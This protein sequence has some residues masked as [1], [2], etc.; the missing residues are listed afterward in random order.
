MSQPEAEP[1]RPASYLV[2]DCGSTL[3]TVLLFEVVADRYR[4][5]GRASAPTTIAAPWSNLLHGLHEA[6]ERLTEITGRQFLSGNRLIRPEKENKSGVD[7]FL[8]VVSAA[9]PLRTIVVGLSDEVSLTSARHVLHTVY[10]DEVD[11]FSLG[12]TRGEDEQARAIVRQEPDLIFLVGGTDGGA[13]LRLQ[14]FART[15]SLAVNMHAYARQIPVLYAGNKNQR[16]QIRQI[17][18][19]D[20]TLYVADNVRPTLQA[21]KLDDASRVMGELYER[22]RLRELPGLN[23]V[24]AWMDQPPLPTAR[25]FATITRYFAAL[26]KGQVLGLELGT[27]SATL[28]LANADEANLVIRSDLGMGHAMA[29]LLRRTHPAAIARWLPTETSHETIRDFIHNKSL[30]PQTLPMTEQE[31]QLEHAIARELLRCASADTA[32]DWQTGERPPLPFRL[33]L[34]RG[35]VFAHAPRP[36]QVIAMILD[37]LQPVGIFAVLLDKVGVLPALGALSGPQPL[38]VVQ[39]L[40]SKVL[41]DL[42]WVVVPSGS[43]QPGQPAL[44]IRIEAE[45]QTQYEGV[46]DYGTLEVFPLAPGRSQVTL[47]PTR[48]FDVGFGRGKGKTVTLAGGGMGLVVDA[49]GRPLR[50]PQ[51][52]IARRSL[53]QQWLYD[54]GGT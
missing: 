8:M 30:F 31:L 28:V 11:I 36:G 27:E 41:T 43:A 44:R 22:L 16:E 23:Q 6:I 20:A 46:V 4:L 21:E 37:A 42:G 15:V 25:A 50:L 47:T 10:A 9:P 7:H 14:S 52:D 40:E 34:A 26:Y 49:R 48:Q 2:A 29:N 39:A 38:A 24:A 53:V 18:G 35:H 19:D 45:N 32:L 3:T 33:I 1:T 13:D 12:D 5:V 17:M 54:I 51:D